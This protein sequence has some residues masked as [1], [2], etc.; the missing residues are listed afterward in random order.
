MN[1]NEAGTPVSRHKYEYKVAIDGQTAGA[2]VL[3]LVGTGKRV[4]DL[5]A[6]PGSITRL[7][8]EQS[9]CRVTAVEIDESAIESLE[10]YCE[11][12]HRVD[13]NEGDWVQAVRG[14]APFQVVVLADVLEHLRDPELVLRRVPEVLDHDGHVVVS[15]PHVGHSAVVACLLQE[16]FAYRDSGLL[17][18]TH[19]RFF[20]IHNIQQLFDGAGWTIDDAAFIVMAP[21]ET[22]FA[23]MWRRLPLH[24]RVCLSENP[25]GSVYQVVIKASPSTSQ[26]RGLTLSSLPVPK[27]LDYLA[28]HSL[29]GRFT[30][31]MKILARHYLS[32][33]D[34]RRIRRLAER[35]RT[36]R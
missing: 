5:G 33:E 18:R 1:G 12:V 26:V 16:D 10:Q 30:E 2:A 9:G 15:L 25:F 20:G 34:R 19:I 31:R 13:L 27:P 6:G 22:E 7:L 17:D 28:Q 36:R 8:K 24:M 4:L 11:A 35:A 3:R 29:Q 21:G 23:G 32:P 14:E